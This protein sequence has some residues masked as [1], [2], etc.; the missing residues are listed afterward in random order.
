MGWNRWTV[1]GLALAASVVLS[2]GCGKSEKGG[3]AGGEKLAPVTA[4]VVKA[5]SVD[6]PQTLELYGTVEADRTAAV[7]SRVMASVTAVPVRAGDT[8]KA[9][10]LLVEIDPQTA[11]GQEAQA[12]GALAQAKAGLA[13]AE[14]NYE[15]F[16]AL[17][18]SGSASDLELD[19]AR[20]QYEQAKGAVEQGSGAVEAASSVARESRVVAPFAGRVSARLVE[21]GDLA[22]P[23]RPLVMIESG[24]GRRLALA[25]PESVVAASHL[26]LGQTFPIRI[27]GLPDRDDLKGRIVEMSPGADPASHTFSVKLEVSGA[28]VPTG[29]AGRAFL[30]TARRKAILVPEAS[31]LTQGGMQLVVV[32]DANGKARSRAVTAGPPVSGGRREVL[33][34]LTGAEEVLVGLGAAP[35]DGSPVEAAAAARTPGTD[36]PKDNAKDGPKDKVK[37]QVKK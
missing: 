29:V 28:R 1:T 37:V 7:S 3:E 6:L 33:S 36:A 13:L 32:R 26:S 16:K 27:D 4:S 21:A 9:G 11:K 30:E 2:V 18:K 19:M 15:R 24:E 5:E 34:G 31:V 14:K 35:R 20:M 17:Q 23:G 25:V 8:V 22:A 12:R 10:Q